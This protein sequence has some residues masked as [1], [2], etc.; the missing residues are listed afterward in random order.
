MTL[1]F[2]CSFEVIAY[3]TT[4]YALMRKKTKCLAII[5]AIPLFKISLI[6]SI[7]MF[8]YYSRNQY[9]IGK[10]GLDSSLSCLRNSFY[11]INLVFIRHHQTFFTLL[12]TYLDFNDVFYSAAF[13]VYY[14]S[15][16]FIRYKMIK[17]DGLEEI[18]TN[19]KNGEMRND[20]REKHRRERVERKREEPAKVQGSTSVNST[21]HQPIHVKQNQMPSNMTETKSHDAKTKESSLIKIVNRKVDPRPDDLFHACLYGHQDI[22]RQLLAH[23][24]ISIHVQEP[25]SGFTAFHL[26][27]AG[28]HLSIVQQLMSKYGK[29]TCRDL[30]NRDGQTGLECAAES[31]RKDVLQTIL[32][33][34]SMK[35]LR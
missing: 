33:T 2:F 8:S 23:H 18:H 34:M 20:E 22:V 5:I 9:F 28:G 31:G 21:T 32:N 15:L 4:L 30:L 19:K 7:L 35:K 12:T 24:Q 16:F 25:I 29:D 27:C 14:A 26:A 1:F 6:I 11:L 10:W 3:S 17:E 13:T